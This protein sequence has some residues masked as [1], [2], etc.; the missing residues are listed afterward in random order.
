[1]SS[2]IWSALEMLNIAILGVFQVNKPDWTLH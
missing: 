2:H 1:M